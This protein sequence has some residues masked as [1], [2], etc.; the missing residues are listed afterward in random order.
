[1]TTEDH[2]IT[3][4]WGVKELKPIVWKIRQI[5][6]KR[7]WLDWYPRDQLEFSTE[8]VTMI[9]DEGTLS[10]LIAAGEKWEWAE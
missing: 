3:V 9:G 8:Y 1:M 2:S 5:K 6:G 4:M 7:T 10:H